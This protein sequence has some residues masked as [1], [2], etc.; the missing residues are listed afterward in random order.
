MDPNATLAECR[1]IAAR[2]MTRV[3]SEA[4]RLADGYR[5]AELTEALDNWLVASGFL[6]DAW[7]H[8]CPDCGQT[9]TGP[10]SHVSER[11]HQR[12][13]YAAGPFSAREA[14]SYLLSAETHGSRPGYVPAP[15]GGLD[16]G[17]VSYVRG[18]S[19]GFRA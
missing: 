16:V 6:P 15:P 3:V 14:D 1:S 2:L 12:P 4:E 5:L 18:A 17:T 19:V 7:N 11:P 13:G 10:H 8:C 9:V